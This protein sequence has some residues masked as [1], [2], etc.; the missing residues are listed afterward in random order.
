MEHSE[1]V[2]PAKLPHALNAVQ[3]T[4]YYVFNAPLVTIRFIFLN[5][6]AVLPNALLVSMSMTKDAIDALHIAYP[7]IAVN[8]V[9]SAKSHINYL[10]EDALVNVLMELLKE[11]EN[12]SIAQ[13]QDVSHVTLIMFHVV[14]YVIN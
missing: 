14:R 10:K 11:T 8:H 12:V 4:H 5:T 7:A 1:P 6:R 9:L 13:T 2:K 3:I